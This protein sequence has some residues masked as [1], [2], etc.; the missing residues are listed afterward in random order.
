MRALTKIAWSVAL[1]AMLLAG[2]LASA[3]RDETPA[4]RSQT[5]SSISSN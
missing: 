2:L 5:V 1:T 4:G 3:Q